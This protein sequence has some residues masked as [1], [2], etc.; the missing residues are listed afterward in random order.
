MCLNGSSPSTW[1]CFWRLTDLYDGGRPGISG[2]WGSSL[3]ILSLSCFQARAQLPYDCFLIH[4]DVNKL[5]HKLLPPRTDPPPATMP[6]LPS[7]SS[8]TLWINIPEPVAKSP[9]SLVVPV[10]FCHRHKGSV[11]CFFLGGVS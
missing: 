2:P 1:S 11:Q 3:R 8:L 9:S 10:T 7:L 4:Q 6:S 5:H